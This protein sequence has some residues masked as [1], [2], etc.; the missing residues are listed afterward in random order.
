M[1]SRKTLISILVALVSVAVI[2]G[3]ALFSRFVQDSLWEKSVTDVLE[4]TAQGQHALDTYFEKD[5][6]TLDLFAA[7]LSVQRHDD[8]ARLIEKLALFGMDDDGTVYVCV[9]LD[10]GTVHRTDNANAARLT[11]EQMASTAAADDRG[12][13]EPFL[14]ERTGGN[15]IGV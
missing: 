10:T 3:S 11:D 7:E 14:D 15:M 12:V 9:D 4:V 1:K 13:L 6:D 2:A 5:L 8:E